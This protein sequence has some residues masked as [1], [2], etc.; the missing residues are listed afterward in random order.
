MW[1]TSRSGF[2]RDSQPA[3]YQRE[4]ERRNPGFRSQSQ[5][6]T[7]LLGIL[8]ALACALAT[9]VGFLYKHRGA[10]AAPAVDI[11]RP[12]WSAKSL[13]AS[14]LFALGMLIAAGAWIFHVAAMTVA[15]LS[16]VQAV[17]AGGVV[18]LAIMAEKMFG[19]KI[20]R[21]QWLGLGLTAL[22]LMLLGVSLPAAHGAHSRFSV[23]GM[24]AFEAAMIVAGSL[25]IIGPRFGART[26]HHGFML[27]A[28]AGILFGVS[29]VAIK[30]ISGMVGTHGALGLISPWTLVTIGASIAA[31]YASAKGLQD[32]DAVPVIAVT[33]TAANVAGIVGGIIVF[34][35]PLSGNPLT[36]VVECVAFLLVLAA[37]WLMPAPVRAAGAPTA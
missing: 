32:G 25:L 26:E 34:G 20:G 17:L 30:A 22:G 11:K 18:L 4:A 23:P 37:A 7:P 36:L 9:N 16:L 15:P 21:R 8:L 13:F 19:L 14:R 24:I 35:D 6:M 12:L 5:L 1:C 2:K 31:F 27:G 3:E 29:D 28:A 33:G 10:C